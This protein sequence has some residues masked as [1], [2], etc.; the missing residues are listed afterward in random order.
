GRCDTIAAPVPVGVVGLVERYGAAA[1]SLQQCIRDIVTREPIVPAEFQH[2]PARESRIEIVRI[3][4]RNAFHHLTL[5]AFKYLRI[6]LHRS[7][8]KVASFLSGGLDSSSV[9]V[10]AARAL[11]ERGKRLSAYTQVPGRSFAIPDTREWYA[12][13]TPYV[14]AIIATSPTIDVTYV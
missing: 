11:A 1:R 9:A 10:L 13:E 7:T 4:H 2:H 3:E 12:D 14:E 5:H 8:H 6:D